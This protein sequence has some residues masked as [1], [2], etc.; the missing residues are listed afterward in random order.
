MPTRLSLLVQYIEEL[1]TSSNSF[2]PLGP[3]WQRQVTTV[4]YGNDSLPLLKNF[5]LAMAGG[6]A[7]GIAGKRYGNLN[8]GESK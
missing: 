6:G 8:N 4:P 2:F 3:G 1:P 7:Q 5:P